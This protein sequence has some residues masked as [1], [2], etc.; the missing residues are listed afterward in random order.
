[1]YTSMRADVFLIVDETQQRFELTIVE[2]LAQC[3]DVNNFSSPSWSWN[4][5][6]YFG[7]WKGTLHLKYCNL[8]AVMLAWHYAG[9]G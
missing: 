9:L 1:M 8:K 4:E 7:S 3:P 6:S 2:I 5:W